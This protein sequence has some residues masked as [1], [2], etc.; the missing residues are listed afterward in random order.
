MLD[1]AAI[2][3]ALFDRLSEEVEAKYATRD[4]V[5][6]SALISVGRY[7]ALLYSVEGYRNQNAPGLP[8]K[9]V[10]E[11]KVIIYIPVTSASETTDD[12]LA[13]VQKVESAL[14]LHEGEDPY[15]SGGRATTVGDLV[16]WAWVTS[17]VIGEG[18]VTGTAA[19]QVTIEMQA[20]DTD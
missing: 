6:P 7:P 19:A 11:A 18:H 8:P 2:H 1:Q 3:Q 15:R 9:V 4:W 13:L 14:L 20:A 5:D 17:V 10:L 16:D 12:V